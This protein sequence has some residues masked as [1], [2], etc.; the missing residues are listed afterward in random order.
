MLVLH[1]CAEITG[2]RCL[3]GGRWLWWCLWLQDHELKGGLHCRQDS[4]WYASPKGGL[5]QPDVLIQPDLRLMPGFFSPEAESSIDA[6]RSQWRLPV[7][8][9]GHEEQ[10]VLWKGQACRGPQKSSAF[11][12]HQLIS[13]VT[14]SASSQS[15]TTS[16][17]T[18]A[19][20]AVMMAELCRS[21]GTPWQI[22]FDNRRK[23]HSYRYI[24]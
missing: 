2:V 11:Q 21:P 6:L 23:S 24:K 1:N 5:L 8:P 19:W 18:V 7:L 16:T 17:S 3:P 14:D 9:A 10:D 12:S 20:S 15:L 22:M 4:E 13:C